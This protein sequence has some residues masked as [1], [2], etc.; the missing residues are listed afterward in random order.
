MMLIPAKVEKL[1]KNVKL[2]KLVAVI[3]LGIRPAKLAVIIEK[4]NRCKNQS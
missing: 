4:N 2:A 1:K 3:E